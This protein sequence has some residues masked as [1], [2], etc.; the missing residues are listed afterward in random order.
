[1]LVVERE[2]AVVLWTIDRPQAK[3]AVDHATLQKQI[4]TMEERD[5]QF[6][7]M[8]KE[9]TRLTEELRQTRDRMAS[10]Q[11]SVGPAMAR[12]EALGN[13]V[14]DLKKKLTFTEDQLEEAR[15]KR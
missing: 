15:R 12:I 4:A 13:E 1:M 5:S 8:K 3:N 7:G 14:K 2:G 9:N 10:A 6:L 11:E